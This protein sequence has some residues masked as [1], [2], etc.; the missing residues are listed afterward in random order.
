MVMADDPVKRANRLGLLQRLS[1]LA[2]GLA[3]FSKLEG[4]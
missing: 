1:A 4:F 2:A 3:D